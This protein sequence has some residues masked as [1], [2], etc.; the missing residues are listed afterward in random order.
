MSTENDWLEIR[1]IME[2]EPQHDSSCDFDYCAN[3]AASDSAEAVGSVA[4]QF[5]DGAVTQEFICLADIEGDSL[6]ATALRGL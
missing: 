6:G 5:P 4:D 1:F 3:L 2:L